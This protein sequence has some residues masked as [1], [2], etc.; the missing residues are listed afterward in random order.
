[1]GKRQGGR[2]H[3]PALRSHAT[4]VVDNQAHRY[5]DILLAEILDLLENSVLIHLE[6]VLADPRNKNS[7]A[8]LHGCVQNDHVNAHVNR[9]GVALTALRLRIGSGSRNNC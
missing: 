7:S 2:N 4:A 3:F 1:M 8:V 9:V 6:V 5:R